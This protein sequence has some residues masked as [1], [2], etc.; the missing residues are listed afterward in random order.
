M[1]V[2]SQNNEFGYE[3]IS[4]I[5]YANYLNSIGK[6]EGTVSAIDTECLYFFSP[7]H[8]INPEQRKFTNTA[9]VNYP[10]VVIHKP[11]LDKSQFLAPNYKK[12]YANDKFKFD[13]ETII[14][15]NRY[16]IEWAVKP[17]NFFDLP[18]LRKI[19]ELLQ[20]RYQL[21]YIN[22]KGL[23]AYYDEDQPVE[24]LGD[25]ELL[26]E[27]PKVINI[28]ELHKVCNYLSFNTLQLM[29]FANCEKYITMNG[30]HSI[31]SAYFG[32]ENII[33]SKFGS[34]MT[35]EL[36]AEN[37]S[38]YR[39]Y[40]E[41]GGQR[42]VHVSDYN[43]LLNRIKVQ[44]ID[45]EPIVN[46]LVRTSNRPNFFK[47]CIDSIL[48]QT[49]VNINI[50][51]SIDNDNDYTIKYPVYPVFVDKNKKI[52]PVNSREDFGK[53]FPYND[54]LNDLQEKIKTGL[55]LIMDDDDCYCDN[56]AIEKIV[57]EYKKGNDLIFWRVQISKGMIIPEPE[58]LGL[59]PELYKMSMIGFAYDSKYKPKF[60]PYKRA[61]YRV[62]R[63]LWNEIDKI[64]T[65]NQVLAC[66]QDGAHYGQATD[67]ITNLKEDDMEALV[68]IKIIND[69]NKYG[70][71]D[72]KIGNIMEI[73]EHIAEGWVKTGI[74]EYVSK[75]ITPP[76]E[77]KEKVETF[78]KEIKKDVKPLPKVKKPI[79][80]RK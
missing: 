40:N 6:L 71:F 30:G 8:T 59:E 37:N 61:D 11:Y 44:W 10:N 31:L 51:V 65:I 42:V 46:I 15:C 22:I 36:R 14:I 16:N 52:E 67:L 33:Y 24:E 75:N 29:L 62:A 76:L 74:A 13:K 60:L 3:L 25:Y 55:I 64:G 35:Q 27:Y 69:H 77:K 48:N 66:T 7:K 18:T 58:K 12:Q 2:N 63:K 23:T 5:P 80:K 20:D 17:I 73:Q 38:F 79:K 70:R 39:W 68:K 43:E 4:T 26:K 41:F 72:V 19:F 32:G 57:N 34:P 28:H 1:I 9:K 78:V 21:V 56:K 54:Y 45:K 47:K 49:Y 53:V 50:Y